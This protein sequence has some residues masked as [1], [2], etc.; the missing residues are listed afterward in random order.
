MISYLGCYLIISNRYSYIISKSYRYIVIKN[1][2]FRIGKF[3][4]RNN[5]SY[6][7]IV[8]IQTKGF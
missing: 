8:I 1:W 5:E 7:Y 4:L 6:R 3:D 2:Y